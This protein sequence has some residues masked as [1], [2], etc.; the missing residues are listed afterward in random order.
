MSLEK[1]NVFRSFPVK[2]T[3][4]TTMSNP[5]PALPQTNQGVRISQLIA[6]DRT[7]LDDYQACHRDVFPGVLAALRKAQIFGR[8]SSHSVISRQGI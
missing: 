8:F 7:R 5:S 2:R 6:L 4:E 3:T 1:N